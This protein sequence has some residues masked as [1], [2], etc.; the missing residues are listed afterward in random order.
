MAKLLLFDAFNGVSG[1]MILGAM[2]DLGLPL[3]YLERRLGAL[4]LEDFGCTAERVKRQSVL[5]TDFR[6]EPGRIGSDPESRKQEGK[7]D[8]AHS[9]PHSQADAQHHGHAHLRA[10]HRSYAQIREMID[11][12]DLEVPVKECA[13]AIFRRLAEAEAG[14]HGT[15]VGDVHFHEVGALDSIVDIVGACIGFHYFNVEEYF[16][17]PLNLGGGT[18]TFSH[19]TWPVPAPA[20]AELVRNFPVRL[21]A[22]DAELTT[23][24]GAAIVT[25]LVD[26][27]RKLPEFV[28]LGA[29]FG[30]GDMELPGIPN[31]LRLVL[32]E[33]AKAGSTALT[34]DL[35]TEAIV[36]LEA[37]IDDMDPE[38]FGYFME[39]ALERG[40]LDVFFV[41]V[42]MKKNRPGQL[43]TVLCRM[44]DRERML[45]LVFRET[46]TLGVRVRT[47]ERSVLRRETVEVE[48]EFG[49]VRCK[50][51]RRQGGIA[52]ISPEFEDLKR[53]ARQS[54]LPL[55]VIR[56]KLFERL[57]E[58]K[59]WERS[60]T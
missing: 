6:V 28:L 23:P 19:G 35:V 58:L 2:V 40:A 16:A 31:M 60:S 59:L 5:G 49:P 7:T 36:Q 52:D 11:R 42:Q 12:A 43:L 14:V 33:S 32:G 47:A 51:S 44:E 37:N 34:S 45:E 4:G 21:S 26:P 38:T 50:L 53:I 3:E 48:S 15:D 10:S 29:G 18:V 41:P 46:T 30:A 56:R 55:R 17:S 57:T 27:A 24:T 13:Q 9:H 39:S 20:T 22:I 54:G 25:T 8:L 1:D